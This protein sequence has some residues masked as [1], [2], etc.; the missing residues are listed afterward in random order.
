MT[1]IVGNAQPFGY[2]ILVSD[3]CVT[4]TDENGQMQYEDCLQ[5]IAY[6]G[7]FI[8]G[9]FSGSVK[10]GLC[11][12]DDLKKEFGESPPHTG[13]I[14]DEIA[15]TWLPPLLSQKFQEQAPQEQACGLQIILA[16]AHPINNRGEAPWPWTD[17][18]VFSHPDFNPQKAANREV[19]AIGSG[20]TIQAYQIALQ[21]MC[22]D[23]TFLQ[24]ALSGAK[25]QAMVIAHRIKSLVTEEPITGV[26]QNF[27]VG[28]ITR[29]TCEIY[30][31]ERTVHNPDG[32]TVESRFPSI[33]KSLEEFDA[34]C[35]ENLWATTKAIC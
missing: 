23:P 12:L 6:L 18:H 35:R 2:S 27:Q 14:V 10:A 21:T 5:K 22:S 13:W 19:L 33:V 17:V 20:A 24:V 32:T 16:S 9:G 25:C 26:S 11:I 34:V 1:W 29:G 15:N 8:L 28:L 30:N 7:P 31:Y 3:I 4:F